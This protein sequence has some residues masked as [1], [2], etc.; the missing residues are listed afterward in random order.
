M[1]ALMLVHVLTTHASCDLCHATHYVYLS[2]LS[3]CMIVLKYV[4][5]QWELC[6]ICSIIAMQFPS[7][8][9]MPRHVP[10]FCDQSYVAVKHTSPLIMDAVLI[11][12]RDSKTELLV[13]IIIQHGSVRTCTFQC[14]LNNHMERNTTHFSFSVHTPQ[15]EGTCQPAVVCKPTMTTYQVYIAQHNRFNLQ[16][17]QNIPLHHQA[18]LHI[19]S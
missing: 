8:Y 6:L 5:N 1:C 19:P 7:R 13:P 10:Y 17:K 3:P 18:P 4:R 12:D 16:K 15:Q 9:R 14:T 11:G 2:S